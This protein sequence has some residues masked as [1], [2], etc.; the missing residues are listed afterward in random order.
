MGKGSTSNGPDTNVS[1][2]SIDSLNAMAIQVK[3]TLPSR[4]VNFGI[5]NGKPSLTIDMADETD[6]EK[7]TGL[8]ARAEDPPLS[9]SFGSLEV[10]DSNNSWVSCGVPNA[11]VIT[12]YTR[13]TSV[14]H[15]DARV[16]A[17]KAGEKY[18]QLG[19]PPLSSLDEITNAYDSDLST[20]NKVKRVKR[21][22]LAYSD[23]Y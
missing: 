1:G 5:E 2:N 14:M 6:V 10:L 9:V 7:L 3:R 19:L 15:T 4:E 21:L 13:N 22:N 11:V 16:F 12:K 8:M 20:I 17:K 18:V 23:N